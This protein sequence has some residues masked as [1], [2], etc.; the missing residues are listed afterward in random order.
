[1]TGDEECNA[2]RFGAL[3][4]NHAEAKAV[5]PI[6]SVCC[7]KRHDS[8]N[9]KSPVNPGLAKKFLMFLPYNGSSS[10]QLSLTS[11]KTIFVRLYCDSCHISMH[12]KKHQN[13]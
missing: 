7:G 13:W 4:L 11:F 9:S 6:S 1:M 8:E 10:G 12:L 2:V 3:A 5:L